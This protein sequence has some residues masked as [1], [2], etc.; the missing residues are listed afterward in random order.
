MATKREAAGRT[1]RRL[2]ALDKTLA[3]AA[4]SITRHSELASRVDWALAE[5]PPCV[6]A[7]VRVAMYHKPKPP[8]TRLEENGSNRSGNQVSRPCDWDHQ[9][10][11]M[12]VLALLDAWRACDDYEVPIKEIADFAQ[13]H[14]LDVIARRVKDVIWEEMTLFIVLR[15]LQ[16]FIKIIHGPKLAR[17]LTPRIS[18]Y[19]GCPRRDQW[20]DLRSPEEYLQGGLHL[21]AFA[22]IMA[23]AGL[24]R[25]AHVMLRDAVLLA[26]GAE[27]NFRRG[28]YHKANIESILFEH[29]PY[30]QE[31][32]LYIDEKACKNRRGR[33]GLVMDPQAIELLQRYLADRKEGALF[34]DFLDARLTKGGFY[35]AL[36]RAGLLALGVPATAN[37]LRRSGV[38]SEPSADEK[39]RRIGDAHGGSR[40]ST[41]HIY[42]NKPEGLEG[43]D[44]IRGSFGLGT[45]P[46]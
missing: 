28:E 12:R 5:L 26:V 2:N 24:T 9:T 31:A 19:R 39:A 4:P 27:V 25:R 22:D 38:S 21:A 11:E 20:D 23:A 36:R 32:S 46:S 41:P 42:Y 40:P 6:A 35:L 30:G 3:P 8:Q 15:A 14:I 43:L 18:Y 33:T 13:P 10:R 37:L 29:T 17:M 1:A 16:E 7:S 44:L 34:S 45:E